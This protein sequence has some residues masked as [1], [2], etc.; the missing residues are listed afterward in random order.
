MTHPMPNTS[1]AGNGGCSRSDR[2]SWHLTLV[3]TLLAVLK[4]VVYVPAETEPSLT[5]QLHLTDVGF[6][7]VWN[8]SS[9][10]KQNRK[11][12]VILMPK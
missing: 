10:S 9:L 4:R 11:K 3:D 8:N 5:S 6:E 1:S 7:Y 2:F 12:I